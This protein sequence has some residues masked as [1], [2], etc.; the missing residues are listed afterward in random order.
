MTIT[1]LRGFVV[2]ECAQSDAR[3]DVL[4]VHAN[5]TVIEARLPPKRCGAVHCG[6]A[7]AR[8]TPRPARHPPA[9]SWWPHAD[10]AQPGQH[11]PDATARRPTPARR[12]PP[13]RC[14]SWRRRQAVRSPHS[15]TVLGLP[16]SCTARRSRR[17]VL[18]SSR[19]CGCARMDAVRRRAGRP[20]GGARARRLAADIPMFCRSDV[21]G[22]RRA[23][24]SLAHAGHT[25]GR[26]GSSGSTTSPPEPLRADFSGQRSELR[27]PN[28][29][30]LPPRGRPRGGRPIE[31][32]FGGPTSRATGETA[33]GATALPK[34]GR[35]NGVSTPGELADP[36][37]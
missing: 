3:A 13:A 36:A 18:N 25:L 4:R 35:Y 16:C 23:Y 6:H 14:L 31:R 19:E 34:M 10:V 30:Y 33:F 22:N 5:A 24:R 37:C 1:A 17:G 12:R 21:V 15:A 32:S 7:Q 8:P 29:L 26:L 9:T 27:P 20:V 2:N 11:R 28:A